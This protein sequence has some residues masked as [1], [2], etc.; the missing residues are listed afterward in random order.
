MSPHSP[1]P[2]SRRVSG[3]FF[4]PLILFLI[5]ALVPRGGVGAS[6]GDVFAGFSYQDRTGYSRSSDG[7]VAFG[8]GL[9][10]P[11]DRVGLEA[12]ITS[13]STERSGYFTRTQAS[14]K[15]H[16]LVGDGWSVAVGWESAVVLAGDGGDSQFAPV[17]R[18][19]SAIFE[20]RSTL[21]VFG[22]GSVRG[23]PWASVIAEWTGQDVGAGAVGD[24]LNALVNE[25]SP[26]FLVNPPEEFLAIHAAAAELRGQLG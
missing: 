25:A 10:N 6:W 5:L 19:E 12:A 3:A 24:S 26:E 15:A 4:V 1:S 16:R 14:L 20:D 17:S 18:T 11:L 2:L 22:G 13:F 23:L 8:F 7:A 9:G 21:G